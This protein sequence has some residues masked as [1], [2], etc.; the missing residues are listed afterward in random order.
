[1]KLYLF[2][3]VTGDQQVNGLT[4]MG[5]SSEKTTSKSISLQGEVSALLAVPV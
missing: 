5:H 3:V 1:M 4:M 2:N